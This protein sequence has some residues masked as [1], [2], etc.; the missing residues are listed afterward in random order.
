[1][2]VYHAACRCSVTVL[3]TDVLIRTVGLVSVNYSF[4]SLLNLWSTVSYFGVGLYTL[5]V[6]VWRDAA[7]WSVSRDTQLDH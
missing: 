2:I 1:M 3:F 4:N 5:L 6:V 7:Y